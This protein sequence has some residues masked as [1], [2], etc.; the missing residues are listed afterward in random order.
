MGRAQGSVYF[1]IGRA[2]GYSKVLGDPYF[3][4]DPSTMKALVNNPGWVQALTDWKAD[5]SVGPPGAASLGFADTRP[6]FEG[7]QA[8]I[9][10]DW[11]DPMGLSLQSDSKITGKL[12]AAVVPGGNRL[13]SY[14]TKQWQDTPQGNAAPFLAVTTWLWT[15]PKTAQHADAA[16]DLAVFLNNQSAHPVLVATPAAAAA[17]TYQT[18]YDLSYKY[19]V[20]EGATPSNVKSFLD[21]HQAGVDNPNAVLDLRIPGGGDYYNAL[22]TEAQR[23][24]SGELTP[25]QALNAA[26]ADWE[27]ITDRLG[28]SQQLQSYLASLKSP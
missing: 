7:G 5:I 4:F 20:Q 24:M 3:F 12:G 26:A 22:D 6:L 28:R 1:L 2:A 15:V 14:K 13:Y 25:Q 11:D 10:V 21:A 19:F 16:W 9:T 27:Q 17:P 18:D 8:A 23:A